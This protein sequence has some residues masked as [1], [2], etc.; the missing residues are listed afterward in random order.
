MRKRKSIE[1]VFGGSESATVANAL[2]LEVMLDIR[3]I[4]E[5]IEEGIRE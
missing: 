5:D 1:E 2:V 4:L 3:E